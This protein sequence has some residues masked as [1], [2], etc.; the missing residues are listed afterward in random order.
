MACVGP[1]SLTRQ[2]LIPPDFMRARNQPDFLV[3]NIK[4]SLSVADQDTI[5]S[6]ELIPNFLLR[7]GSAVTITGLTGTQRKLAPISV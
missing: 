4:E 1:P 2:V 7:A 5:I 3:K 6:V